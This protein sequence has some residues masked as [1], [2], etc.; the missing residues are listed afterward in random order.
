MALGFIGAFLPIMPT[1][2][3][4]LLAAFCFEK[5]SPRL[6][7][8]IMEHKTFGPPLMNWREHRVIRPRAKIMAVSGITLSLTYMIFFR[9]IDI[10]LKV[11]ISAICGTSM[12]FIL[13][14]RNYPPNR[15]EDK[16]GI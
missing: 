4:L 15:G 16:N 11:L 2:P 5:G 8:W 1:V 13:I 7:K 14:Q 3:F 6:H 12:F 10:W 9:S